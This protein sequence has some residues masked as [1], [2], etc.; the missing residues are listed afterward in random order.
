MR[1]SINTVPREAEANAASASVN[2]GPS[3]L[4][5]LN[6]AIRKPQ[7]HIY[8]KQKGQGNTLGMDSSK[9]DDD[10]NTTKQVDFNLTYSMERSPIEDLILS[11]INDSIV[12][13]TNI[14]NILQ[15]KNS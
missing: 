4:H 10:N 8:S 7:L 14:A 6:S 9:N 15:A 1:V 13:P 3:V 2:E 12:S 5:T 11:H